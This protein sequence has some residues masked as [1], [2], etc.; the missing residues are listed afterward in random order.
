[1]TEQFRVEIDANVCIGSGT[2]EAIDP[3]VFEVG[4]DGVAVLVEGAAADEETLRRAAES[5]PSG[6]IRIVG[7]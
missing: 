7:E 2:C 5:C 6:A 3:S 1:M 4:D